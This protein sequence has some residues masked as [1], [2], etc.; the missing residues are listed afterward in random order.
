MPPC[1]QFFVLLTLLLFSCHKSLAIDCY[2]CSGTNNTNQFQC[3][4]W[5]SSVAV[6]T[7]RTNFN[8]D[9]KVVSVR[10]GFVRL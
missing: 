8:D 7:T 6:P 1:E 3:N 5:L 2:Q 9:S 4:E 10:R